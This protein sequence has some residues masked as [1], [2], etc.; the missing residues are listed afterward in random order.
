MP[1]IA[2]AAL[3]APVTRSHKPPPPVEHQFRN[4]NRNTCST[5]AGTTTTTATSSPRPHARRR[6]EKPARNDYTGPTTPATATD[7]SLDASKGGQMDHFDVGDLGADPAY[8]HAAY[9]PYGSTDVHDHGVAE[10]PDHVKAW[11][12]DHDGDGRP[13]EWDFDTDGD[14]RVDFWV[15]DTNGDGSDDTWVD[16]TNGDGRPDR[17]SLDSDFDG[18]TD[19]TRFD[20]NFDGQVDL[21][22]RTPIDGGHSIRYDDD[23]DG[24]YDR[25]ETATPDGHVTSQPIHEPVGGDEYIHKP[26]GDHV[27][28]NHHH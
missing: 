20:H 28:L 17:V 14:G 9:D 15:F 27:D 23:Y 16:D 13:D 1:P 10:H 19:E 11:Q 6:G 26:V 21:D 8:D 2:C 4:A 24:Y 3:A 7:K 22:L 5:S 25:L 18:Q 12:V